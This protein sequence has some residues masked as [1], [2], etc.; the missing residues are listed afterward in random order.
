MKVKTL[1]AHM[2]G[3]GDKFEKAKG[4]EYEVP[5]VHAEPLIAAGLVED[6]NAPAPRPARRRAKKPA[7]ARAAVPAPSDQP[8][9]VAADKSGDNGAVG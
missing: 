6:P 8:E 4:D 1:K 3:Y 7:A 2:N 9:M 5:D